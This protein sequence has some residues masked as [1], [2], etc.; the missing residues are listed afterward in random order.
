MMKKYRL[1]LLVGIML[2]LLVACNSKTYRNDFTFTG[3]GD[4]W[5]AQYDYQSTEKVTGKDGKRSDNESQNS[6]KF[7]LR[8]K[9]EQTDLANIKQMEFGFKTSER[10][11]SQTLEGPIRL[12]DLVIESRG[13]RGAYSIEDSVIQVEVEWEGQTEQFELK[14]RK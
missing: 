3:E 11:S 6:Y 13:N 1:L 8:Y 5:S 7:Q 14:V 2:L 12:N 10:E 9:G 4:Q